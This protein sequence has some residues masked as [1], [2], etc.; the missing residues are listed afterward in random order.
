MILTS[1]LDIAKDF[2]RDDDTLKILSTNFNKEILLYYY[3]SLETIIYDCCPICKKYLSNR[4][5]KDSISL[6][7]CRGTLGTSKIACNSI[8]KLVNTP[9]DRNSVANTDSPD[10][11]IL[12]NLPEGLVTLNYERYFQGETF[13]NPIDNYSSLGKEYSTSFELDF[14]KAKVRDFQN[15]M[16]NY[17]INNSSLKD[18]IISSGVSEQEFNK[19]LEGYIKASFKSNPYDQED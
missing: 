14:Y 3:I 9:K 1:T 19:R 15:S 2:K 16:Y 6:I 17:F 12:N 8:W 13:I 10:K 5:L 11:L 7:Y 4:T 18:V